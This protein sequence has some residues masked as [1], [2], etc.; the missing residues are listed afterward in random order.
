MPL[1]E[2]R[3]LH[4][5]YGNLEALKG[6]SLDVSTG[7]VVAILGSN[8]AGKSTTLR[9]ISG[10]MRRRSGSI[11][12]RGEEISSTEAHDVVGR[13]L[14]H[15]P[16]GR[17]IFNVLTVEENL[18]L[19][20]YTH[21]SQNGVIRDRRDRVYEIFPRLVERRGQLAGTLSGGEQQMLA[22]GRGLM[23]EPKL[24]MLDEPSLGLSP[25]LSKRI[26]RIIRQIAEQGTAVLLVEQNA[27]QALAISDRAYVLETGSTVLAGEA[28]TLARDPRVQ[29]AYLGGLRV[30]E[31]NRAPAAPA[32]PDRQ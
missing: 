21:R 25:I 7:E 9:T 19:G 17:R 11:L 13:G 4:V 2:V 16:E 1:L 28:R 18:N 30:V 3:D 10:L 12:F 32:G 6:V 27:R 22:I 8:G 29:R 23:S 26:L 31:R 5:Y 14:S 24:L 15:V 20:G